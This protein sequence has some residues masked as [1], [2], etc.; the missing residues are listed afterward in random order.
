MKNTVHEQIHKSNDNDKPMQKASSKA[1]SPSPSLL[2]IELIIKLNRGISM[3]V[4]I[5]LLVCLNFVPQRAPAYTVVIDPGHGGLDKGS[6]R[7]PIAESAI[8]LAVAQKLQKKFE[9]HPTIKL[10]MTRQSDQSIKLSHRTEVATQ[11]NADLFISLHGNSSPDPRAKGVDF[12]IGQNETPREGLKDRKPLTLILNDLS[13]KA[14][15]FQ[16][17]NLAKNSYEEWHQSQTFNLRSV[18]QAPFFV[19]NKNH[20]PSILVELGF[21]TNP[22]EAQNLTEDQVQDTIV[23][24]LFAAINKQYR[25]SQEAPSKK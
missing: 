11:E 25:Q 14:R 24:N 8:T 23:N 5:L 19:I 6:T 13:Y 20:A 2:L 18:R 4:G 16:S 17:H 15:L 9:G 7:G 10:K 12:F 3:T 22:E 21:L 1:Q